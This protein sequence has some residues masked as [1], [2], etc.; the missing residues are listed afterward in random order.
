MYFLSFK[1]LKKYIYKQLYTCNQ[2]PKSIQ[3]SF[4]ATEKSKKTSLF[5]CSFR[6]IRPARLHARTDR[7]GCACKFR[8]NHRRGRRAALC[9]T[10][11]ARVGRLSQ[12]ARAACTLRGM[13]M[14]VD[15]EKRGR[16]AAASCTSHKKHERYDATKEDGGMRGMK[17]STRSRRAR[18]ARRRW[19]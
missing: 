5:L 12:L 16:L 19:R 1:K 4:S 13:G 17:I 15:V 18:P 11:D 6:E 8:E 14:V 10:R 9:G 3:S 7:A 2:F